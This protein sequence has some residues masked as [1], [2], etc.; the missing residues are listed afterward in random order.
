MED[1]S[2]LLLSAD[3]NMLAQLNEAS[4]FVSDIPGYGSPK[5]LLLGIAIFFF[6][7]SDTNAFKGDLSNMVSGKWSKTEGNGIGPGTGGMVLG[8][9]IRGGAV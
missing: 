4:T 7:W 9:R 5:D 8:L 2:L 1:G 3:A 6:S